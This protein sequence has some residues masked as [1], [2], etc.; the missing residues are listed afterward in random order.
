MI[1]LSHDNYDTSFP[2]YRYKWEGTLASGASQP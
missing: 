2:P 1:G